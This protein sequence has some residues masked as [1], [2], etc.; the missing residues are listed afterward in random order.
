MRVSV[1]TATFYHLPFEEAI[2]IICRA[3]F[4][5]IELDLYWQGGDWRVAQHLEGVPSKDTLRM[6]GEAGLEVVSLHD[7]GGVIEADGDAAIDV[8][9]HEFLAQVTK[10]LDYLV[11]HTP[12]RKTQ[13][14]AEWWAS[15]QPR[16]AEDLRAYSRYCRI[17]VENMPALPG[18]H[19]PLL[20]PGE[21]RDFAERHDVSVAL[22]TTHY[23]QIGVDICAAAETLGRRIGCVHLSDFA[24]G[25]THLPIGEGVLDL[26]GFLHIVK[27]CEQSNLSAGG[28][29]IVVTLECAVDP[30]HAMP[31]EGVAR[32]LGEMREYVEG[33][34]A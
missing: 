22:D 15:Y 2:E 26:T 12:H 32:R 30:S 20:S 3:G 14:G 28:P 8:Q 24:E 31:T 19:V 34:L 11:V 5:G 29:R 13:H 23:A 16:F 17:A 25:S 21:L 6:I 9:V 4:D 10:P 33:V 18:Y 7:A 27:R 1:A